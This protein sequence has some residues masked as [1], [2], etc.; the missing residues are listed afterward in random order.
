MK[1]DDRIRD[2]LQD[3]PL[4]TYSLAGIVWPTEQF[5]RAWNYQS[6]GG[7]P[8]W[9]LPLGKAIKRMGLETYRRDH[10]RV[11]RLPREK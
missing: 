6:N 10:M 5:P 11:V 2:A 4:D 3:G 1:L 7:P 9:V 8:G